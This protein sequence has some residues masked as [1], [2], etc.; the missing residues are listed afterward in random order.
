MGLATAKC[1]LEHENNVFHKLC[2]KSIF[3]MQG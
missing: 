1:L 3:T 2:V